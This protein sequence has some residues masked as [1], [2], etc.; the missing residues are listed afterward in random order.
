MYTG[1][2]RVENEIDIPLDFLPPARSHSAETYFLLDY[3]SHPWNGHKQP[4][5]RCGLKDSVIPT[6]AEIKTS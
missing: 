2:Q 6:M 1:N 5:F 3:P 4:G